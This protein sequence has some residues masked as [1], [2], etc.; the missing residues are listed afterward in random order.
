MTPAS[1]P[2]RPVG[3]EAVGDRARFLSIHRRIIGVQDILFH[4]NSAKSRQ[5]YKALLPSKGQPI[6]S[7][8][9]PPPGSNIV[10]STAKR[11]PM[12]PRLP[13]PWSIPYGF[14][15]DSCHAYR[16]IATTFP[17][18]C[19]WAGP[20][21]A[22]RQGGGGGYLPPLAGLADISCPRDGPTGIKRTIIRRTRYAEFDNEG[23]GAKPASRVSWSASCALSSP[24]KRRRSRRKPCLVIGTR[25]SGGGRGG[26]GGK[27]GGDGR[28][29]A[30]ARD[31][32]LD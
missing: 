30:Q 19:F 8:A 22:L 18:A 3:V 32:S 12:S 4:L 5:Y 24:Q 20:G 31:Y 28:R 11:T 23:P 9:P 10:I 26:G 6:L 7:S 29:V 25:T 16:E 2:A 1:R 27:G 21:R 15:F 14:V 17:T 13:P